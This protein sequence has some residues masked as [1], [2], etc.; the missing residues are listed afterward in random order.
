MFEFVHNGGNTSRYIGHEEHLEEKD[1]VSR[2]FKT[3]SKR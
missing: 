1:E 2:C 3:E